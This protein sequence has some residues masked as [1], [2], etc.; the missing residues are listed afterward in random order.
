MFNIV[1]VIA[2][3]ITI[4]VSIV[5]LFLMKVASDTSNLFHSIGGSVDGVS[6]G[7]GSAFNSL[8]D[9]VGSAGGIAFILIA[10]CIAI[11]IFVKIISNGFKYSSMLYL[12]LADNHDSNNLYL[13]SNVIVPTIRLYIAGVILLFLGFYTI[14]EITTGLLLI[15]MGAYSIFTGVFFEKIKS[16]NNEIKLLKEKI[17][18][19]KQVV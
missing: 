2:I 12:K 1:F 16:I 19:E 8:G 15:S 11:V 4:L 3:L 14:S 18:K 6:D 13:S 7:L 5:A 10:V 9:L 17:N